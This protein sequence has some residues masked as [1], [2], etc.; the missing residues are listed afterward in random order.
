MTFKIAF[1]GA[2]S[3]GFTRTLV[4]DLLT[5]PEFRDADLAFTDISRRNLE[6]ASSTASAGSR[7]SWTSARTSARPPRPTASSSTTRTRWP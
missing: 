7:R 6:A 4:G 3:I 1:I 5:V 2:G